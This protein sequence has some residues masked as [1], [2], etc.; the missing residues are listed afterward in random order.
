[1]LQQPLFLTICDAVKF[2]QTVYSNF[3]RIAL[4]ASLGEDLT[5]EQKTMLLDGISPET[6][7]NMFRRTLLELAPSHIQRIILP[8]G[9]SHAASMGDSAKDLCI[10]AS[11]QRH[12]SS[13]EQRRQ[14]QLGASRAPLPCPPFESMKQALPES[15]KNDVSGATSDDVSNIAL[16]HL[17]PGDRQDGLRRNRTTHSVTGEILYSQ[18]ATTMVS[19]TQELLEGHSKRARQTAVTAMEAT[20]DTKVKAGLVAGAGCAAVGGTSGALVGT[21]TGTLCGAMWGLAPAF[22]TFGLSVPLGAMVGGGAGLVG[23]AT[24]G[25]GAGAAVGGLGGYKAAQLWESR[26]KPT[27]RKR[28]SNPQEDEDG[29]QN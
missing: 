2:A 12:L 1:M 15:L 29:S 3:V 5:L 27:N 11:E 14:R 13:P 22:F 26:Q 8:K 16:L 4:L 18:L 24:V 20:G 6:R 7:D 25:T 17:L 9:I 21:V 19:T 28:E 10:S 23:G